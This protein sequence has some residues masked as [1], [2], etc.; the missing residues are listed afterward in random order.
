MHNHDHEHHAELVQGFVDE[1]QEIF[2][3]SSQA[4]YVFLDDDNRICN[5]KFAK[6]LGYTSPEEWRNVDVQGAFPQVFIDSKSQ[7]PLVEAYQNAM[8]K[9]V[10]ASLKVS[11][12]KK[13]G[14]AVNT[15]VILVPVLYQGH[16]FALHFIS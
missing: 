1:Q 16:L 14:G 9:G 15:N 13:N 8:E 5:Q 10:A 2:N 3:S 11:W 4:M 6:L 7:R 12:K